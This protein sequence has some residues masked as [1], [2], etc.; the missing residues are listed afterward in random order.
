MFGNRLIKRTREATFP[1]PN[2][3]TDLVNFIAQLHHV[4][5]GGRDDRS[6]GVRGPAGAGDLWSDYGN[7]NPGALLHDHHRRRHRSA[8][9]PGRLRRISNAR[10]RP[11][12]N[13]AL[14]TAGLAVEPQPAR[15]RRR[16]AKV[17]NQE[18][19]AAYLLSQPGQCVGDRRCRHHPSE[20]HDQR[21][22]PTPARSSARRSTIRRS[23]LL[24]LGSRPGHRADQRGVDEL[25]QD[26][27]GCA[28]AHSQCHR[29]DHLCP[30]PDGDPAAVADPRLGTMRVAAGRI[31]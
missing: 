26:G 15:W 10:R 18:I 29:G 25:R 21:R 7:P 24:G 1:D 2:F 27:R 12:T 9:V 11:S 31:C 8:T 3:R 13:A 4:R 20:R 30:V 17:S 19:I 22:S 16:S 6:G 14:Q 23:L 5:P 28:S